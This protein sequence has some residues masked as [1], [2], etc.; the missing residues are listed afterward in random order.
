MHV[1]SQEHAH[2][3]VSRQEDKVDTV[4]SFD[5]ASLTTTDP[6]FAKTLHFS[7]LVRTHCTVG[8][9]EAGVWYFGMGV[10]KKCPR[11]PSG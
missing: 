4:I 8:A 9:T 11:G 7:G 10:K 1:V 3:T 5:Q 6:S 2:K